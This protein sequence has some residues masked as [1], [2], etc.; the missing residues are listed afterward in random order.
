MSLKNRRMK[1]S[2][3]ISYCFAMGWVV[4]WGNAAISIRTSK[5][6]MKLNGA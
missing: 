4:D 2:D 1:I 6:R 3:A 5:K